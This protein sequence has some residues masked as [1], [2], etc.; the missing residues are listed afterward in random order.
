MVLS[1]VVLAIVAMIKLDTQQMKLLFSDYHLYALVAFFSFIY[2]F[3]FKPIYQ[4]GGEKLNYIAT[5][6]A[7]IWGVAKFVLALIFTISFIL[8]IGF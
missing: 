2:S 1:G 3:V 5:G 4:E 7:A 6:I 8:M